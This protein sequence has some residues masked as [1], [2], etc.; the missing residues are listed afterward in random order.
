MTIIGGAVP[1][2]NARDFSNVDFVR[3]FV[4]NAQTNIPFAVMV[5]DEIRIGTTWDDMR[6]IPEPAGCV[7]L[8]L[9]GIALCLRRAR[10]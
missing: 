5:I 8:V 2:T 6:A 3:P 7:L 10:P 1:D 4:G 9:G